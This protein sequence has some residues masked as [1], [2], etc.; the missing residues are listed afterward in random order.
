MKIQTHTSILL[1]FL[2]LMLGSIAE[3]QVR[4]WRVLIL[5]EAGTA[6][7]GIVLIDQGLRAAF[8][9]SPR[10]L[11]FYREYLDTL[12]FPDPADQERFREFYFR[13]YRDRIPD[14]I[15][16]VGPSPLKFMAETHSTAF[17][18]V[19][20]VF[21]FPSWVP[22]SSPNLD[23]DFTGVE[24]NLE[25]AETIETAKRLQPGTRH[26][27]V[28]E[29][30]SFNDTQFNGVIE[31]K[32][33]KYEPKLEVSYLKGLTMPD[34]VERLS[35][36]PKQTIVLSGSFTRDPAG[37]TFT[38]GKASAMVTAAANAPVF[39]VVDSNFG[40]GEVGGKISSLH[41]QGRIAGELALRILEGEKPHDIPRVNAGTILMFDWR[42]LKRWGMKETALPPGSSVL[43]REP[44]FWELYKNY[45]LTAIAV[46]LVETIGISALLRQR[47]RRRKAEGELIRSEEKFSKAF[48]RSPF[49]ITIV[50]LSDDRHVEVNETFETQ[51][52]WKREQ[53]IG[54]SPRDLDLWVDPGQ[55]AAFI[56]QL[57]A[58]GS[59]KDLEV[60]RRR[61]D[62]EIRTTLC[63]AELID[64]H[65]EPCA[66]TV[67]VD[68]TER[69]Q[70]EEAIVGFSRRLIEAQET[71]RARIAREL[72]DDINQ[73]LA[74]VAVTLRTGKEALPNS[75]EKATSLLDEAGQQVF[76]LGKDVQALSHQLHSS[77]L[78]Y[79]GLEAASSGFCRGLS[80][81]QNV[82]VGFRSE[83]IP[84]GLSSEI[85][86]SLFRV[87]QEALHNAVKYSGV[88]AFEVSL[89]GLSTAIE[90]R[91]HDSG[92]GFDAKR[93]NNGQ[94]LGLISMRERLKLVGGE[95]SIDSTPG[96]GTTVLA[97]VP[98]VEGSSSAGTA[99]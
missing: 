1:F 41:E 31:D 67:I 30:T 2:G 63:S 51:T 62:G 44:G 93:S 27:V 9:T 97:R 49:A 18:G 5:N 15:I 47:A 96:Q 26:I 46:F 65:G 7:P 28:V 12:L 64:V 21:C 8:E 89:T 99:A 59:V 94:G 77:K 78:E 87:L 83:G 22:G 60:R 45:V 4:P 86:L 43:N 69:K 55:R 37:S 52:G 92:V 40:N 38:A 72:H 95:L 88:D 81:R 91:V 34:L 23:S 84:K 85:A 54:R 11:E 14:L 16:T 74:L 58:N 6:W 71:E 33:A 39:T 29:G 79:L 68:I 90:M 35:N 42:A 57:S 98:L 48:R 24:N 80:E 20:I 82:K 53:V 36:L 56:N 70:A 19:P 73:R 75:Q 10:P 66:L 17:P 61:K 76:E 3:A 32:L 50:R 25:P 13:K